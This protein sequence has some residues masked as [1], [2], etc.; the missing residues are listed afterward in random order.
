MSLSLS[1]FFILGLLI[2]ASTSCKTKKD[3]NSNSKVQ[4]KSI[5]KENKDLL[6]YLSR[7]YC[8]GKCPVD[9]VAIYKNGTVIYNGKDNVENNG[10]YETTFDEAI[11]EELKVDI[12]QLNKD[13]PSEFGMDVT[14]LPEKNLIIKSGPVVKKIKYI[15]SSYDDLNALIRKVVKLVEKAKFKKIE[16]NKE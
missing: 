1:K 6:I 2:I 10:L 15:R 5:D 7:G 14:D 11:I 13:I 4:I 3:Q 9:E 8:F 12:N 16:A